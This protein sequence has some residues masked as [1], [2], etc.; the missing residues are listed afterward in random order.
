MAAVLCDSGGQR[1]CARPV[2]NRAMLLIEFQ[3]GRISR[4]F[5]LYSA[6]F[7]GGS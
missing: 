3:H 4:D 2:L 7:P 5:A 1:Q 6:R